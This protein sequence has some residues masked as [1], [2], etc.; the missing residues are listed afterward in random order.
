MS[1]VPATVEPRAPSPGIEPELLND[2][3][4][5][6]LLGVSVRTVWELARENVLRPIKVRNCTRWRRRDVLAFIDR[7]AQEQAGEGAACA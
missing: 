2:R 1:T 5:A 6:A 7:L 3:G 4:T